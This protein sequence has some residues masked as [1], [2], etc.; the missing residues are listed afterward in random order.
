[1]PTAP[2]ME[3]IIGLFS[4]NCPDY[5]RWPELSQDVFGDGGDLDY[6]GYRGNCLTDRLTGLIVP[7][8]ATL[9]IQN[10]R[11]KPVFGLRQTSTFY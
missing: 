7:R 5:L 10:N 9:I 11:G 8:S 3:D 1:M 4:Y 2:V 6:L